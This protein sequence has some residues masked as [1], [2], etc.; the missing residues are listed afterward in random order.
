MK[1]KAKEFQMIEKAKR[2]EERLKNQNK[3]G[4]FSSPLASLASTFI[5]NF[6]APNNQFSPTHFEHTSNTS[7]TSL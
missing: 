7:N 5:H 3:S 1:R 4:L 6:T 2:Q